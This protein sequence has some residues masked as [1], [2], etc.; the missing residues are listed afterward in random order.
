[1]T[2]GANVTFTVAATGTPTPTYQWRKNGANLSGA[3]SA[4]LM[5]TNVGI[6]DAGS[7]DAIATNAA[8]S[9][10]STA[11]TLIVQTLPAITTQPQ[12]QTVVAGS[13]VTFTVTATGHAGTH[14]PVA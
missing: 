8:G 9:A 13:N 3:T 2:A 4:S 11:A 1:V 10:T 12:S 7:Y 6:A 14:L 5:L